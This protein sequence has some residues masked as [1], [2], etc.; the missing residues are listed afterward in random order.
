MLTPDG[1]QA[2]IFVCLLAHYMG[3][4]MRRALAAVSSSRGFADFAQRLIGH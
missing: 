4:R 2:H 1:V 3:W